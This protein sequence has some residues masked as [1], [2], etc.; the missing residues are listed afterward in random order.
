MENKEYVLEQIDTVQQNYYSTNKKKS[1]LKNKQKINCAAYVQENIE[2]SKLIKNTV[3]RIPNTNIIYYDYLVFK[4]YGNERTYLLIY[5]YIISVI[6]E[7]LKNYSFFE[8]H[9]NMKTFSISACQRYKHIITT[10]FEEGDSTLK[11]MN[12][13]IVYNTPNIIKQVVAILKNSIKDVI[14]KTTFY[15]EKKSDLILSKLLS[16]FG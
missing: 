9:I 11:Y 16:Q 3:M 8:F 4:T 12:K 15:D 10:F 7:I 1:F 5:N 2:M 13:I 14:N 6:Q